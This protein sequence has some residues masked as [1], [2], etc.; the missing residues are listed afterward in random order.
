MANRWRLSRGA[1]GLATATVGV[2][3][4]GLLLWV[5]PPAR[6][7][8]QIGR[9]S[10]AWA[11]VAVALELGSC[12]SYVI[13]FRYFFP[14]TPRRTSRRVA[15]IAMGAGAVLPG[16]N[17]SS[18]AATGLLLRHDDA[19]TR[20]LAGR[21]A[22]LLCLLIAFG[23][24]VNGAAGALLLAGVPDGPLDASH[25]GIPI[26]VSIVVLS[27][28]AL[29]VLASR[30]F[31]ERTPRAVRGVAAGLEGAWAAVRNPSWRL[32]G[33]AGFMCLDMAALW[34]ACAAT[35]HRLGFLAVLI[36]YCIGYL[37]TAVPMPAGLG[38]LDSGLAGALVL[39][40]LPATA[41]VGAVLVYHAI[42]IWVPGLGALIAWLSTRR[43]GT[44]KRP[45]VGS[46]HLGGLRLAEATEADG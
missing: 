9:M 34:A 16:G 20:R 1:R 11:M 25:A 29:V 40:G 45:A 4:I 31:G 8:E 38:V 27:V 21:C 24:A 32:L 44:I 23:F 33:A 3:S 22:S 30:R 43:A 39:Y 12:L 17:I 2:I 35:G 15:W 7:Y 19:S 42:A 18:A 26:V 36:A 13:V 37:A 46:S 6:V 10:P 28:A 41:S 5:A 14:E